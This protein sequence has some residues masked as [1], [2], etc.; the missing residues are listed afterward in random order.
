MN[1]YLQIVLRYLFPKPGNSFSSSASFLAIIGLSIGIF[2]LILTLS[3]IKGF[4]NVLDKK[5]S[6][7][8]GQVRVQNILGGPISEPEK[9]YSLLSDIDLPLEIA[10]Y[11]RGTAMIRVGGYTDGIIIEG[12][13]E[14]PDKTYF[15]SK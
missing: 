14:V 4:E 10:P 12:I 6:G 13:N 9:L 8:D 2:S 5:L 3:I 7:I 1:L 15:D 11:I